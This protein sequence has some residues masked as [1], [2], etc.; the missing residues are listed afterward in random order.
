MANVVKTFAFATTADGFTHS[1]SA[2]A[3]FTSGDGNPAG[4]LR[5]GV[6]GRN[7]AGSGTWTWTGTFE[8]LGVPAGTTVTGYSAAS[9]DHRCSVWN[10]G[11]SPNQV[12]AWS[13]N[14]GTARTLVTATANYTG[15]TSWA[16]RSA[17]PGVT[18]L[19][20][21]SNT[22]VSLTLGYS[23]KDGNNASAAVTVGADNLSL[24]VEYEIP[25]S[26]YTYSGSGTATFSG[27]ATTSHLSLNVN[28]YT[29][30]GT[31]TFSGAA[32]TGVEHH[33]AY[34]PSGGLAFSGAALTEK[35][36]GATSYTYTGS[37]TLGLSGSAATAVEH[38]WAVTGSGGL[39]YSGAAT[40]AVERHYSYQP[41]GGLSFSGAAAIE[42]AGLSSYSYTG[43]GTLALSGAADLSKDKS[44]SAS[45]GLSFSG[46]AAIIW[47]GLNAYR[48]TGAGTLSL[49]G[50]AATSLTQ[51]A[52]SYPY[53][54]SGTISL[55]GSAT[56]SNEKAQTI[57]PA[58]LARITDLWQRLG[59]DPDNPLTETNTSAS[60]GNITL[61][62]VGTS[63]ITTSRSGDSS[64]GALDAMLLDLWRRFGLDPDNPMT[65]EAGGIQAGPLTMACTTLADGNLITRIPAPYWEDG[66]GPDDYVEWT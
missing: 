64:L 50:A 46:T 9:F 33:Y 39:S 49:S 3:A 31:A 23:I 17:S 43:S 24:T 53:T 41:S 36:G 27:A 19:S 11:G 37:G 65:V 48:Y 54:G 61:T 7:T 15:T 29:G 13:I 2:T 38:H 45:G 18:G 56:T 35:Q 8:D 32:T 52:H 4:S 22:S 60:F 14:D 40:V 34:Q 57:T 21:P 6:T 26:S 66:Y 25:V 58:Q 47:E 51:G 55:S 20:L 1:G 5:M 62:K 63:S 28:S 12:G 10:V 16:N 59:L 42:W 30:S 44:Y